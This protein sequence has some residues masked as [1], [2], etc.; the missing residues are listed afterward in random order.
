MAERE[1]AKRQEQEREEQDVA[2]AGDEDDQGNSEAKR[3]QSHRSWN[4]RAVVKD[5]PARASR[6]GWRV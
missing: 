1:Q 4:V 6:G 3:D 5:T 2:A